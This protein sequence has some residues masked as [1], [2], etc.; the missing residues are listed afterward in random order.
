ME[1]LS[2]GNAHHQQQ[3]FFRATRAVWEIP[4]PPPPTEKTG[5]RG[6]VEAARCPLTRSSSA[7]ASPFP[8]GDRIEALLSTPALPNG[9]GTP[10]LV[11]G[12]CRVFTSTSFFFLSSCLR[13]PPFPTS[14]WGSARV[15]RRLI[16]GKA[17]PAV[18]LYGCLGRPHPP[19]TG[20]E[21]SRPLPGGIDTVTGQ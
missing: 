16:S 18:F 10:P 4:P 8:E 14:R 19:T 6:L 2:L 15:G 12:Q 13:E 5:H 7:P 11:F 20:V 3:S 9:D 1:P 17:R 21:Q